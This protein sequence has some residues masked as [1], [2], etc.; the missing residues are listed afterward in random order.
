MR[1][2]APD[3]FVYHARRLGST[4]ERVDSSLAL[5]QFAKEATGGMG[6]G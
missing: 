4:D 1:G 5:L 6:E 2:L 3:M